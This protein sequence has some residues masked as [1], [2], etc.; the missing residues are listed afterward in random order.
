MTSS[1]DLESV[2]RQICEAEGH[3]PD[4][5]VTVEVLDRLTDG[6]PASWSV[7]TAIAGDGD[8]LEALLARADA[9]LYRDKHER[10]AAR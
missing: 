2:A 9:A 8:T 5:M 7:G 1:S 4:E 6:A 10:R 3:D